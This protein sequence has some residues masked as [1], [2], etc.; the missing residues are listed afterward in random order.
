MA[1][2]EVVEVGEEVSSCSA[3]LDNRPGILIVGSSGVGK[4][5]L[6]SRLLS[7][8]LEDDPDSDPQLLVRGWTID[9]KYYAADVSV[10][11]AHLTDG[12]SIENFPE[13]QRL[14][15]L[16]M[17]FDVTD[18]SSFGA[19]RDWVSHTHIH[20]FEILLCVGNKVDLVSGHPVHQEYRRRLLMR[21][22][23]LKLEQSSTSEFGISETEG[24]NL[25]AEEEEDEDQEE[26]EEEEQSSHIRRSCLQWCTER[27]I[28]FIEA[29][30]SNP[31][32]DKCLSVD[33]D[34]QGVDR[35]LGALSAHMWPGMILKSGN[36]MA[37]QP[38]PDEEGF[39]FLFVCALLVCY[40]VLVIV[41]NVFYVQTCLQTPTMS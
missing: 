5:T 30:V 37:E 39:F 24:T 14:V 28:E 10:W 36:K 21:Q 1:G 26:E 16:V 8:D 4:R 3:S 18:P 35:L 15:A 23:K 20:E 41:V 34:S 38:L 22:Q 9:T 40:F 12:F 32:F 13:R 19:V 2:K 25:L 31:D 29:C 33:G 27:N 11:V 17:V 6:L 7:L